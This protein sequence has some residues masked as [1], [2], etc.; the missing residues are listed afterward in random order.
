MPLAYRIDRLVRPTTLAGNR[1]GFGVGVA[2][3]IPG[4]FFAFEQSS[5]TPRFEFGDGV[6]VSFPEL[7]ATREDGHLES[8]CPGA[9]DTERQ[10]LP[11]VRMKL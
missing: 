8:Y 11:R 6:S 3:G 5:T 4:N 10:V 7:I 2:R 1:A 9:T